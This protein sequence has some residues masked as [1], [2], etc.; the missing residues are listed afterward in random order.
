MWLCSVGR[1]ILRVIGV[2]WAHVWAMVKEPG[3]H[4]F[5]SNP[6]GFFSLMGSFRTHGGGS[7]TGGVRTKQ[8]A[9]RA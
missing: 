6:S 5:R 3:N 4:S 1:G 7:R 8:K 2:F 9:R